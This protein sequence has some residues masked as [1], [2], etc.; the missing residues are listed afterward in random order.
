MEHVCST[1]ALEHVPHTRAAWLHCTRHVRQWHQNCS[2]T[3]CMDQLLA[4]HAASILTR[5]FASHRRAIMH[6]PLSDSS[7]HMPAFHCN[8]TDPKG[9]SCVFPS[10]PYLIAAAGSSPEPCHRHCHDHGHTVPHRWS[11]HQAVQCQPV[12]AP[13]SPTD[14]VPLAAPPAVSAQC[15]SLRM[16]A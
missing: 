5:R 15:C 13:P 11:C 3:A 8:C 7:V 10:R 9:P 6:D 16:V 4:L 2:A 1:H 14:D 12:G